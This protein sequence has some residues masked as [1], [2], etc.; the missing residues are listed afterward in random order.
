MNEFEIIHYPQINGLNIFFNT[1]DYRT[2]HL[3][4][5]FEL[6]WV[7]DHALSITQGIDTCQ[8]EPD[9]LVLFAPN[10]PHEFRKVDESCTFLCFQIATKSFE[11]VWPGLHQLYV[12]TLLPD[13]HLTPDSARELREELVSLARAYFEK[14]PFYELLCQAKTGL[15]LH[16]LFT[17]LP[18]RMVSSSEA[19]D[20]ERRNARLSRL[21]AYVDENYM[22]KIR[23][24]DFAA[25]EH[26]SVSYL[27][28]FIRDTM[29]Q[30]FQDY[31]GMVR[32]HAA[33]K[34]IASGRTRMLD[35][36]MESG[37]SDYRYFSRAFQQHMG[38]T[39]EQYSHSLTPAEPDETHIHQSLH[40]LEQFYSRERCLNMLEKLEMR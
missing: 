18:T 28:H 30:T 32:F 8:V 14:Q 13:T 11:Q 1:V 31:V 20:M 33:C 27:S 26:R 3:H 23:L 25:L 38:M 22:H 6:I 15:I 35:V 39:P 29:N 9:T 2:P 12:D 36:C 7:L 17:Q 34:L 24:S 37:F 4:P 16:R 40:S 5:E 19:Q 21:F 10:Q